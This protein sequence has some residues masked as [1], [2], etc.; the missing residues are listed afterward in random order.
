MVG[1]GRRV[2]AQGCNERHQEAPL[3]I[4]WGLKEGSSNRRR[5]EKLGSAAREIG[6]TLVQ[7]LLGI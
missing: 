5:L 3:D 7:S 2:Q 4:S 6:A 1:N